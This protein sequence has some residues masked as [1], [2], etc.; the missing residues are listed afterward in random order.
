[1]GESR[2]SPEQGTSVAYYVLEHYPHLMNPHER[3]VYWHLTT[4][5]KQ[6]ENGPPA[7]GSAA[8]TADIEGPARHW[9]ST[10]AGVLNDAQAGWDA[11]RE[12]IAQ[13]IIR[14]HPDEV[15]LNHCPACGALTRTPTARLCLTCGHSWFHVPRDQ[16]L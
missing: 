7:P 16:R 6:R 14:D 9:L 2:I 12:K 10:D 11:A 15:Y 3:A 8:D 1:M 13:R 4:L 5:Y